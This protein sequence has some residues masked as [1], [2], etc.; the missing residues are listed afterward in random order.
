MEKQVLQFLSYSMSKKIVIVG[1][2]FTGLYSAFLASE[3]GHQVELYETSNYPGGIAK[4]LSIESNIKFIRGCHYLQ[5]K[6]LFS[7]TIQ[8]KTKEKNF[9][10]ENLKYM[11]YCD[12][13]S[14]KN[15]IL[16][17]YP[18]LFFDGDINL[19]HAKLKKNNLKSRIDSYPKVISKPL[20]EWVSRFKINCKDLVEDSNRNGLMFSRVY[21]KNNKNLNKLKSKEP[22]VDDLYGSRNFKKNRKVKTLLPKNGYDHFFKMYLNILKKKNVKFFFKTPIKVNWKNKKNL[23]I[24]KFNNNIV[25]DNIIWTGNPT[26]LIKNYNNIKLDSASINIRFLSFH[27]EGS[28]KQSFYI[29]VYSK[30]MSILRIFI[31]KLSN[32]I[33]STVECFDENIKVTKIIDDINYV[34]KKFNYNLKIKNKKTFN[35]S[36]QKRYS[37]LTHND[38]KTLIK[39]KKDTINSNLISGPWELYSRED[40]FKNIKKL[41][42]NL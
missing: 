5:K 29:Q 23:E 35:D 39:F 26:P 2:G 16:D 14:E 37:I 18:D 15:N 9:D 41:I 6:S 20:F 4:D 32:I 8:K 36:F 3:M 21:L 33:C 27:L 10:E 13:F 1:A 11:S 7:E 24:M 22:N 25:C 42:T 28:L 17:D 31:Y 38:K 12:L 34:L 30:K 19:R 40:K